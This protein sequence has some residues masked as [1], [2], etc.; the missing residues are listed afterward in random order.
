MLRFLFLFLLIFS[1]ADAVAMGDT[2]RLV[3]EDIAYE[4]GQEEVEVCVSAEDFNGVWSLSFTLDWN[5]GIFEYQDVSYMNPLVV[6]SL[7]DDLAPQGRLP[8]L[9][10]DP[11]VE[12]VSLDAQNKL[13]C[14][15]FKVLRTPCNGEAMQLVSQPT[16]ISLTDDRLELP[17]TIRAGVIRGASCDID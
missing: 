15:K 9:W 10:Y 12:G 1:I 14:L 5:A 13:M 11:R 8:A 17:R 16:E 2:I 4:P 6:F 7:N 3:V